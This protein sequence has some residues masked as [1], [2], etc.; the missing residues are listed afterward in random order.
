[1]HF[2]FSSFLSFG[3]P[4]IENVLL[5]WN[6][7]FGPR[8]L[9]LSGLIPKNLTVRL[10]ISKFKIEYK[11]L[12]N[13]P[14]SAGTFFMARAPILFL[15]T[16]LLCYCLNYPDSAYWKGLLPEKSKKWEISRKRMRQQRVKDRHQV[17]HTYCHLLYLVVSY[18]PWNELR[19]NHLNSSLLFFFS[20]SS[21]FALPRS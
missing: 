8:L 4:W 5:D 9:E 18:V 15:M 17:Q 16:R 1:M 11:I 2:F 20:P 12:A 7:S 3:R 14:I 13:C 6:D 10:S 19:A 21:Y